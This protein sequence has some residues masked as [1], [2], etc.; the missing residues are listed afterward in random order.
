MVAASSRRRSRRAAACASW[1]STARATAS[2]KPASSVIRIDCAAASCSACASRS[3]AIQARIVAASAT[4]QRPPTG[5]RS[6]RCRRGRTPG[7]WRRRH[8]RC[9]ARRS[10]R[11]ARSS[12]CRRPARR[13]PGRRRR[14]RSRST[15]ARRAA[16]STSGLSTPSGVG[17][18]MAMRA[19][20]GDPRRDGVHQH[21]A[22][23]RP[24]CRPAR[25]GRPRRAASSACPS[26]HARP[27]RYSRRSAGSCARW[28][29]SI[30][31]GGEIA[32]PPAARRASAPRAASISAAATRSVAG[33]SV[34]PVEACGV[35]EQRGIAARA[36]RRR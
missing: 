33:V 28:K 9:P 24:P 14:D 36:R 5:R 2:A 29:A 15:P 25:R 1:R 11:P 31:V 32:A 21:R 23:D 34:E 27:R 20:A 17:T 22:T 13:S 6:C 4:H 18:H 26:V 10:C 8:R 30:R 3:T 19:D 35:V 16:A 12:R 7:A